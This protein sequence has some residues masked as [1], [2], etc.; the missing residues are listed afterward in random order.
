MEGMEVRGACVA[1]GGADYMCR[2]LQRFE[3]PYMDA[4]R[5]AYVAIDIPTKIPTRGAR[6]G[7]DGQVYSAWSGWWSLNLTC[8]PE[9]GEAHIRKCRNGMR[10]VMK[11]SSSR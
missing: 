5:D 4:Y 6:F 2:S 9:K 10:E 11:D 3:H 8:V 7:G 1:T